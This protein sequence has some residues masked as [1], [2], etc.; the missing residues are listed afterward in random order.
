MANEYL[1]RT[2]T[3]T[4]NQRVFTYSFWMKG[5]DI[6]ASDQARI[7]YNYD[8]GSAL[9]QLFLERGSNTNPGYWV[10]Y[11]AD[12]DIRWEGKR[13]DISSWYNI[14]LSIDSTKNL[15]QDRAVLYVN[16]C[17]LNIIGTQSGSPGTP[18]YINRNENIFQT[19]VTYINGIA[20]NSKYQLFD[21][22]FVDGQALT[23]DVFGFNK[24]G[25]GY[26]SA[27]STQATDFRPGQWVPKTPRVIKTEI[28]RRGGFGVNG[29]YLPMNDSR[30][31]GADF[32]GEPN[33][34]ITLN[35]Q[36]PQPRVGVA[37]TASVGLGYTDALRA[38]P[39]AANLVLAV[40]GVIGG[41]GSGYGDYS[42]NIKGSG[43]N[44]TVT[45]NGNA[46]VALTASYYGSALSFDGTDDHF[47]ISSS[48]DFAFGAGDYTIELWAY[49][50]TLT[51]QQTYFG[52]TFGNTAGAYFYKTSGNALGMYYSSVIASGGTLVA[53][54]WNHVAA[55]RKS[56][57]L[58][59]YL[60]GVSVG[61][62]TN[63]TTNLTTT[64]Y[65]IGDTGTDGAGTS[66]GEMFG[67]IQDLRIYKGVAKYTG[68]FDVPRP[69]TPVGIATWRQVPDTTA[70]NFAT[71]NPLIEARPSSGT[72][73]PAGSSIITFAGGNLDLTN[74]SNVGLAQRMVSFATIGI[75]T[76]RWYWE[77]R[78]GSNDRVAI[79]K[80]FQQKNYGVT[81]LGG[82]SGLEASVTYG[83]D[84]N[85]SIGNTA[86][87]STATTL[88]APTFDT[89]NII[90]VAVSANNGLNNLT[91]QFFKDGIGVSTLTGVGATSPVLEWFPTKTMISSS[92]GCDQKFNFGQNPTFSGNT[93]AGTFTDTNGKGLFK[94][95]PPS[96]FLALCEDNLP[97]PAISDPGKHFKT[98]LYTGT[99][100]SRGVV[101]VGFTPDLIWV[102]S[103]TD[104]N[105]HGIYDSVRGAQRT[106]SSNSTAAES[107]NPAV[108]SFDVDGFSLGNSSDVNG[109]ANYVAWCWRAGAGTTSTNTNGSITSVVSVNQDAGFSIVSYTGN[110]SNPTTVGHGIGK[111]PKFIIFKRRNSAVNWFVYHGFNSS[112]AFEGL[113]TTNAYN[114]ALALFNQTAPTSSVINLGNTD[115]NASGG[116]YIAYC[117]AE[118]EGFSKF[119]SYVGNGNADGPF[120]YC[121]FKPALV[122]LKIATGASD[123]WSMFDNSRDPVNNDSN[124]ILY[125]NLTNGDSGDSMGVDKLSNGFKIRNT[126]V[127]RYNQSGYTYIFAAWAESPFQTAN[128]K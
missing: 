122:I 96:G 19:N 88:S 70:N 58:T 4:G 128:S 107:I 46:G 30:N 39:Y 7:V 9:L 84:G 35:E 14:V 42:A 91:I 65:F 127:A 33:S 121:G 106:L 120:V 67:Y 99:S 15:E 22:F 23:P 59:L 25:K 125:S 54:Q 89:T 56:G 79:S 66:S 80:G 115:S 73:S 76:G 40:P 28:N 98:V 87:Y 64:N 37:T 44:K 72:D 2:H 36:L 113:N 126:T 117:W 61:I 110:G 75:S 60:N 11:S 43:S 92:S 53:N 90:G 111:A 31:F 18:N 112:G 86:Y 93:T 102:K 62:N 63:D 12:T 116:T 24:Q 83:A 105:G 74:S 109:G 55:V 10:L 50:T 5:N 32:H 114:S 47:S 17:R 124:L 69:Y 20:G 85:V 34:I 101:G 118:I 97:T 51:G 6:T 29:F 81:S 52:D 108:N 49:H 68:G 41:Q 1:R 123:H 3:S 71:M 13:I 94:Y 104:T 45:S 77:V 103:R 100:A 95:Q 78:A 16:G 27:G 38:D 26:I 119:G 21:Y 8:G 82:G 57:V 48:S